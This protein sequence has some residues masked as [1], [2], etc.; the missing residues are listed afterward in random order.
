MSH[1]QHNLRW[2]TL[3]P[4][5]WR[6]VDDDD[7][8]VLLGH[9]T[10]QDWILVEEFLMS[11]ALAGKN[12]HQTSS[13]QER[14]GSDRIDEER[15]EALVLWNGWYVVWEEALSPIGS[16]Q[17]SMVASE[18]TPNESRTFQA[19]PKMVVGSGLSCRE[20]DLDEWA[21]CVEVGRWFSMT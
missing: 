18:G 11:E 2:H 15:E 14:F 4:V 21:E 5:Q 8:H 1:F 6:H 13:L 20:G 16:M 10:N 3:R 12:T 19:T 7:P 9:D 17:Y